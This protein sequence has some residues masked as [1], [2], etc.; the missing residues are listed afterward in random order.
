MYEPKEIETYRFKHL[1]F[2]M[3]WKHAMSRAVCESLWAV[4]S[5]GILRSKDTQL[6]L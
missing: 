3:E 6:V 4:R 2:E 5:R 1:H